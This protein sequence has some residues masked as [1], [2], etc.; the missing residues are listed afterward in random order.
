MKQM[1]GSMQSHAGKIH[2]QQRKR[3]E[4]TEGTGAE[5]AGADKDEEPG[6]TNGDE[7][8][9]GR[10]ERARTVARFAALAAS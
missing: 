9:G 5:R 8:K 2:F 3:K 10:V 4:K 1:R 6:S 7:Q